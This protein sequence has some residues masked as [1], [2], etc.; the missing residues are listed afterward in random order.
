M[1]SET[2]D[3]APGAAI[4]RTGPNISVVFDS[5]YSQPLYE[6]MMPSTKPEIHIISHVVRRG[7][8]HGHA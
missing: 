8:S 7:P 4:W 3:F 2:E 6:I 1:Q 5:G